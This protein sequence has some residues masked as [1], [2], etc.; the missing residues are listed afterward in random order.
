MPSNV[1]NSANT[2]RNWTKL[3]PKEVQFSRA[4]KKYA[5]QRNMINM[6]FEMLEKRLGTLV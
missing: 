5:D 4:S 1:H 6:K 2:T 3:P